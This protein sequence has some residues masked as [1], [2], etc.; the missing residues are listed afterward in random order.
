MMTFEAAATG[1]GVAVANRGYVIDD[2]TRGRLVAPFGVQQP[3][4]NGWYLVHP[5]KVSLSRPARAFRGWIAGQAA[6]TD[7]KIRE[8]LEPSA[9]A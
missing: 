9:A 4:K 7:A 5:A 3:N 8:L 6:I 2:L 1:V